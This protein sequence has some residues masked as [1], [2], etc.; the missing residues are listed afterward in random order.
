MDKTLEYF[1]A[2]IFLIKYE[3]KYY[4]ARSKAAFNRVLKSRKKEINA[5]A[6][7]HRLKVNPD[8]E[9]D[10]IMLAEYCDKLLSD[11]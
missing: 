3:G 9:G 6:K 11:K 1:E 10:M 4:K 7:Q 8:N 2:D 5:F